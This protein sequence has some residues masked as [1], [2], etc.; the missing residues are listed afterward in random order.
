MAQFDLDTVDRLL[1]TTRSVRKRMD[2][3]RPV[4]PEVVK[5]CL[6]LALCAPSAANTQTWRWIVITDAAQRAKI[7]EIWR[8]K[9]YRNRPPEAQEPGY[10]IVSDTSEAMGRILNSVKHLADNLHR[11]P[12]FVIPC[13]LERPN[14]QGE[15]VRLAT[16]YGSIIQAIW[17]L[18]LALRSRGLAS[19]WTTMHLHAE[20]DVAE[21]LGVPDDV[22]QI[23]LIP[24]AHAI[25]DDFRPALRQPLEDV[26]YWD[27]WGGAPQ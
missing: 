20:E 16:M 9:F 11:V 1:T 21:I 26:L 15:N 4:D 27:R 22:T 8:T 18:Q 12:V 5:E 2:F 3:D 10:V 23:A 25:G 6:R 19:A 13:Y 17:S 24:V 14:A 7:A